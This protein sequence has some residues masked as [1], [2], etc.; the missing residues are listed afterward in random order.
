MI[1][2]TI[3]TKKFNITLIDAYI[4]DKS[5]FEFSLVSV[6]YIT[7]TSTTIFKYSSK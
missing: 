4:T 5:T 6:V 3:Y 1:V 7:N 2:R